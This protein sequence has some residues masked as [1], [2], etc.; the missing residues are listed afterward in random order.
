MTKNK[1]ELIMSKRLI[2]KLEKCEIHSLEELRNIGSRTAFSKLLLV[3]RSASLNTLYAL[4]GAIRGVRW[5]QLNDQVKNDLKLFY[6]S[7][8]S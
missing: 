8:K 7:I 2:N 3:D 5:H 4:E 6:K 1:S